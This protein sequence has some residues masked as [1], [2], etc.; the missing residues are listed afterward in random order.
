MQVCLWKV[1]RQSDNTSLA[2]EAGTGPFGYSHNYN[3]SGTN[4]ANPI[5]SF[6]AAS[7]PLLSLDSLT[8]LLSVPKELSK[9]SLNVYFQVGLLGQALS[10]VLIMYSYDKYIRTFGVAFKIS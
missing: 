8:P 5:F 2:R 9:C 1:I 7:P 10:F 6:W 4:S 3:W